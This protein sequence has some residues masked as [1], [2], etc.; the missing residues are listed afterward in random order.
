[1]RP[2]VL[3]R[4]DRLM[5]RVNAAVTV[6][7]IA[8]VTVTS[9]ARQQSTA[10][11]NTSAGAG[12]RA[13]I[14]VCSDCHSPDSAIAQLRA[15]D[16]WQAILDQMARYGAEGTDEE[17]LQILDYLDRNFSPIQVNK[18]TAT[19]LASTLDIPAT[20]A[21][22]IVKRRDENGVFKSVDDLKKVPGLDSGK[23]DARKDRLVFSRHSS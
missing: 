5:A 18:A 16:E 1:M 2:P 20:V 4:Y 6:F 11:E 8:L 7:V 22:A 10:Q 15:R 21:E 19:H 3:T 13:F 12:E 14:K 17:F 23:V 9:S